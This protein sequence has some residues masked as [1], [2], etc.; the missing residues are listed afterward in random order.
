MKLRE[1]DNA[2]LHEDIR[3]RHTL[4]VGL[5]WLWILIS[6]LNDNKQ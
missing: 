4:L 5:I 1:P 3:H 6:Y 2:I